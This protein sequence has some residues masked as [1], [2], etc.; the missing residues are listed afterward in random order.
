MTSYYIKMSSSIKESSVVVV[1]V[2][3]STDY[4]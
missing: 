1:I 2:V 3:G 4:L